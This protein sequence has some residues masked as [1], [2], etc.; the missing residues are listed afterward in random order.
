[1]AMREDINVILKKWSDGELTTE[2]AN[3]QLKDIDAG[4]S[5]NPD[6]KGNA[7]IDSG[8]GSMDVANVV[9][10]KLEG[11]SA[12]QCDIYYGGK[13]WHNIGNDPTLL[14]GG[15]PRVDSEPAQKELDMKR[16][17]EFANT[18][19]VQWIHGG[20]FEVKYDED[21]YA[22]SATRVK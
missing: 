11:G 16:K 8:V 21:G 13:V 7:L 3:K 19:Q 5:L 2:E 15:F 10:G 17:M 6:K 14:P 1:M 22:V 12:P 4:I 9:D 20:K 18:V